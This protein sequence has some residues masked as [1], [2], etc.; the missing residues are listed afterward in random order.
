MSL[1]NQLFIINLHF[2]GFLSTFKFSKL[3]VL[4]DNQIPKYL[5][6]YWDIVKLYIM[7]DDMKSSFPKR[8]KS[9]LIVF[10]KMT[11]FYQDPYILLIFNLSC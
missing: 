10:M 1:C 9:I 8:S 4:L 2:S 6:F 7:L 5:I 3:S 11:F